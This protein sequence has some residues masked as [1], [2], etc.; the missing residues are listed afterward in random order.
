M[1]WS[2]AR[3]KE[4]EGGCRVDPFSDANRALVP[5]LRPAAEERLCWWWCDNDDDDEPGGAPADGCRC[6]AA[7]GKQPIGVGLLIIR[8]HPLERRSPE[9]WGC[10]CCCC[11]IRSSFSVCWR[12]RCCRADVRDN[13]VV[14]GVVGRSVGHTHMHTR[15]QRKLLDSPWMLP[16]MIRVRIKWS[17]YR[18]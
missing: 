7:G 18:D 16:A 15:W 11:C 8:L 6:V 3:T 14:V 17:S 9:G 4:D 10:C 12:I 1:C 5:K 13:I 2:V